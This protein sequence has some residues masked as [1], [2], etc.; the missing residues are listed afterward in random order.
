MKRLLVMVV[1]A[2]ASF[3]TGAS[4]QE[5][6]QATTQE[7]SQGEPMHHSG[8]LGFHNIQAPL[9]VRW[10][11]GSQ[12]VALDAGLGFGSNEDAG[13]SYTNF[14][15]DVGA[16]IVLKSWDRVHFMVR[17][18]VAYHSQQVDV[19]A[20]PGVDKDNDT[21]L[22]ISGLLE[23]EVFLAEN[24]SVSAAHGFAIQNNDPA[25]GESTTDYGT[26]GADFSHIGFHAY[27]W[28]G[29]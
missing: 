21:S 26:V 9:G 7:S 20:G 11:L 5:T 2:F 13:E 15:L 1:L 16:P 22:E 17:P 14:T 27:L 4:A 12:K 23:A 28:G 8:A 3:A 24:F 10:W 29:R 18:G 19:L 6:T 25:I